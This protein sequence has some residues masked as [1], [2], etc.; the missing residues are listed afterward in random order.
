MPG[1]DRL[2]SYSD[3]P[4]MGHRFVTARMAGEICLTLPQSSC[5][6]RIQSLANITLEP[7]LA[8]ILARF[9]VLMAS[10]GSKHSAKIV[11][12]S[13]GQPEK[14]SYQLNRADLPRH[15]W[16]ICTR[17]V[18]IPTLL[19]APAAVS[20]LRSPAGSQPQT[21]GQAGHTTELSPFQH[22]SMTAGRPAHPV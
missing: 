19:F 3:A 5:Q 11:F 6:A 17:L 22:S 16:P 13:S 9:A 12:S 14:S 20:P 15:V 10:D 21:P 8:K 4:P 7:D 18:T 2:K 1:R